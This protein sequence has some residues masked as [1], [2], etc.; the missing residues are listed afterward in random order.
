MGAI[1]ELTEAIKL[2]RNDAA[3]YYLRGK[4]YR[5]K[6]RDTMDTSHYDEAIRD[7]TNAIKLS[8]PTIA[9][10]KIM[11]RDEHGVW[12]GVRWDGKMAAFYGLR[13]MH[14]KKAIA[15]LRGVAQA[16]APCAYSRGI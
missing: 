5:D 9:G 14:E 15:K 4:A 13:E 11:L 3:A 2:N 8:P 16:N 6:H 7:I 1:S 10:F 12:D